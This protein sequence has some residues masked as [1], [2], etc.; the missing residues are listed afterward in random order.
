MLI[1][2]LSPYMEVNVVGDITMGKNMGGIIYTPDEKDLQGWNIMLIST[3]YTN[4]RGKSVKGGIIPMYSIQEQFHHQYQLG[5][6]KEPL[7]A[8]TLQLISRKPVAIPNKLSRSSSE[9]KLQRIIPPFVQAKSILLFGT[10][11]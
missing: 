7:L 2:A 1:S 11:N 3:E 9:G 5:D 8:A 4:C 10:E 6:V